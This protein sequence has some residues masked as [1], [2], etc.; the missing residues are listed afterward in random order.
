MVK[1]QL[2]SLVIGSRLS[3]N[4][5]FLSPFAPHYKYH[6]SQGTHCRHHRP[7]FLLMCVDSERVAEVFFVFLIILAQGIAMQKIHYYFDESGEKGFVTPDFTT[8]DI[9]L[10]AGIALP[11]SDVACFEADVSPILAKADSSQAEKFHATELFK[12]GAN[13]SV[14]AELLDFLSA[15]QGWLLVY[16][17]VYPLGLYVQETSKGSLC[18]Q[19]K[20]KN[21]RVKISGNSTQPRIYTELLEGI[22]VKLDEACRLEGSSSVAM[23]SDRIDKGIFKEAR[24]RLEYLKEEVHIENVSGFDTESKKVVRGSVTSR[25]LGFDSMVR[26]VTEI[27]TERTTSTMT[28]IAD[29]I[30]N[31]LFRQLKTT[32]QAQVGIRLHGHAALEGYAL[33]HRVAF[34]DDNYI[35]DTLYAPHGL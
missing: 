20:P 21:P 2:E 13:A 12:D 33:K 19:H 11:S 32:S 27:T 28:I 10:I 7:N 6:V 31:T 23:L 1:N 30:A 22:V 35:M 34:V 3:A 9:G 17:A 16:E 5:P 25:V 14:K 29:I 15:R 8:A 4:F 24:S 26:F 18:E